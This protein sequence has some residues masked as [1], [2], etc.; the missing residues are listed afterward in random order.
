MPE[1]DNKNYP[2]KPMV[3]G[4]TGMKKFDIALSLEGI[5]E[6]KHAVVGVFCAKGNLIGRTEYQGD[7]K[8]TMDYARKLSVTY[9]GNAVLNFSAYAVA[10]DEIVTKDNFL[11][12]VAVDTNTVEEAKF[13][14]SATMCSG[15]TLYFKGKSQVSKDARKAAA[16]IKAEKEA[17]EAEKYKGIDAKKVKLLLKEGG[18]KGQD[19]CGMST[20]GV[21]CFC[22]SIDSAEGDLNLLRVVMEGFNAPVDPEAEDRKGGA[23]DLAKILFSAGD[24]KLAIMAHVPEEESK[25]CNMK[26]WMAEVCAAAGA[27]V[28]EE[29]K[30]FMKAEVTADPDKGTFAL[31]LRD[32]AIAAGFKFLHDKGLTLDD[33]SDDDVN[34]ADIAGVDLN[35]GAKGDDDYGD[36]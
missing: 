2:K 30:H 12:T 36:Y 22:T 8:T 31:K 25:N 4:E 9:D 5:P 28:I 11:G 18:K 23:S 21:H 26:E 16:A 29:D 15:I 35:A 19:L 20:F 3:Y 13:D 1:K 33:D 14:G 24:L 6:G 34:Y 17:K 7:A 10:G 27:K 32:S